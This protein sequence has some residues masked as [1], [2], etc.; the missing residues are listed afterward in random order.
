M[1]LPQSASIVHNLRAD[2]LALA[3]GATVS[4]WAET[5]S[6]ALTYSGGGG[7][8]FKTNVQNGLPGVLFNGTSNYLLAS[9]AGAALTT[10]IDSKQYTVMIVARAT[11]TSSHGCMWGC[12]A[13]GD[14]LFYQHSGSVTSSFLGRFGGTDNS[15]YPSANPSSTFVLANTSGPYTMGSGTGLERSFLNGGC[16][17]SK[18]SVGPNTGTTTTA[19]SLG[20]INSGATFRFTGYIFDVVVWSVMLTPFEVMQATQHFMDK[21]AI[22]YPWS[23]NGPFMIYDGNSLTAG[24]GGTGVSTSYP[25]LSATALGKLP[26]QWTMQGVGGINTANLKVKMSEWQS[27]SST[28][29]INTVVTAFEYYNSRLT[30]ATQIRADSDAYISAVKALPRTKLVWGTS[31]G[32]SADPDSTRSTFDAS[33]DAVSNVPDAYVPLHKNSS[34]GATGGTLGTAGSAS[35]GSNIV[36]YTASGTF[37]PVIGQV[38]TFS[39]GTTTF[40]ANTTISNIISSNQIMV[41]N[42]ASANT[43]GLTITGVSS[44]ATN[45]ATLWNAD[46][47]HLK[48]A[49]YAVLAPLFTTAINSLP[50]FTATA[51]GIGTSSGVAT[52]IGI[53]TILS[54]GTGVGSSAGTATVTGVGKSLAAGIGISNGVATV[55]GSATTTGGSSGSGGNTNVPTITFPTTIPNV[56]MGD[57]TFMPGKTN[58]RTE[59]ETGLARVRRRFVSAPTDIHVVW[60]LSISE[61]AIFE[62]FYEVD[63]QSGSQWFNISLVNGKGE[64]TY[65]ARFKEPYQAKTSMREFSWTVTAVLEVPARPLLP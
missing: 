49:G 30:G 65:A 64:T 46:G 32:H 45:S 43:S 29:N 24:V 16:F 21:Y 58:E 52:V 55:N 1:A 4:S 42:N 9:K 54:T 63:L 15:C 59:M 47:V 8:T 34:L 60:E 19:F 7:A 13:G 5:S 37:F 39:D 56:R 53:G 20:S 22:T 48:D 51:V 41:S 26:G 11:G 6:N 17:T 33:S 14:S 40:P 18:T 38:V 36:T 35:T 2:S 62:K 61:L 31:L 3:D 44:Y 10:V 23:T 57:Y 25:Y 27:I 50:A 28:F 12:T